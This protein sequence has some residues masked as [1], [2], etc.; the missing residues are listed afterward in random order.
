M[1]HDI[2]EYPTPTPVSDPWGI[3]SGPDGALWFTEANA[4]QIGRIDPTTHAIT[5]YYISHG[6]APGEITSGPDGALWFTMHRL[7]Q[8]GRIEPT[9][10]AITKYAIHTANSNPQAITSGPDG[11]VWFAEFNANKIG[12]IDPKTHVI[13]EYATP[14]SKSGPA[15]ITSGPDGALW[16]TE[17]YGNKIGRVVLT[18]PQTYSISGIVKVGN[19]PLGGID[20]VLAGT[21][22]A[23]VQT[24]SNGT[25]SFSGLSNGSYTV[26]PS[27][28]GYTFNPSKRALTINNKNIT[29]K[30]FS[31]VP[32]YSISGT[33]KA[34]GAALPGVALTLS[35]SAKGSA[36]SGPDGTYS[37]GNLLKGSYTVKPSM[38]EIHLR[39]KR[40]RSL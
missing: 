17:A 36:T 25:Y 14:T 23:K 20:M 31:A 21:S 8:I 4:D 29:G 40:G 10:H 3:T 24:A 7:N 5:E 11:A 16:F 39:R 35:G 28:A 18:A 38:T 1:T 32:L 26:T 27:K 9:T 34:G 22:S 33:V 19:A 12:R 13:T 15:G 30:N 2:T 6:S 37:F